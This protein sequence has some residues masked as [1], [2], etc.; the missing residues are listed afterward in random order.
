MIRYSLHIFNR[1][2]IRLF[3]HEWVR[4]K[5]TGGTPEDPKLLFGLLYSLRSFTQKLDPKQTDSTFKSIRTET[6]KLHYLETPT[7]L[8]FAFVTDPGAPD[9]RECLRHIYANIFV[10]FVSKNAQYSTGTYINCPLFLAATNQFLT[11]VF[12]T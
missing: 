8:R 3:H 4:A 11:E 2:G 7:G 6:Y 5:N 9:L 1:K 12:P 10:E